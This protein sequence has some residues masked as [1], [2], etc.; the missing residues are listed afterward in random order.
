MTDS[1]ALRV[2]KLRSD[3]LDWAN[4]RYRQVDFLPSPPS[5]LIAV[6]EVAG[7][8]AGLG[9][10]TPLSEIAGELGG[11]YVFPE[12]RGAGISS[13]LVRHLI[14]ESGLDTLYCLPFEHLRALYEGLGF[15]LV[16]PDQRVP[17]HV[18]RKHLWCNRHYP[19]PVLMMRRDNMRGA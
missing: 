4:Q 3:E 18:A 11:M 9:R 2:R 5:D 7:T 15:R 8:P 6:A 1:L 13:A 12:H 16:P 17:D 14:D 10:V 19:D